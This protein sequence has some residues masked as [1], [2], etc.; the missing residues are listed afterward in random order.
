MIQ[1]L[2]T[3]LVRLLLCTLGGHRLQRATLSLQ[4]RLHWQRSGLA[5]GTA[6]HACVCVCLCV[7]VCVC[8]CAARVSES[9]EV[10]T[11]NVMTVKSND[12]HVQYFLRDA[13]SSSNHFKLALFMH[14]PNVIAH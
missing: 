2:W 14:K 7:C 10:V 12:A 9:R 1:P 11:E 6:H 4:P 8:V 3:G 13:T 5:A